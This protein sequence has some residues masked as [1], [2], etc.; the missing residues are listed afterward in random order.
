MAG[1]L[2]SVDEVLRLSRIASL[3]AEPGGKLAFT[4]SR[5]DPESNKDVAELV[6]LGQAGVEASY[7]EAGSPAWGPEG[8]LAFSSRRGAGEKEKGSG[9]YTLPPGLRGEPRRVAW[10]RHGVWGL[11]WLDDE[12][13]VA[14]SSVPE[15]WMYDD[16]GDYVA[17]RRLPLWFDGQ[18]LVAGR[19]RQL[20]L[21]EEWSGRTVK[22]TS[23]PYGVSSYAACDGNI[24]Y[25]TPMDWR[26]PT[27]HR[28]KLITRGG[29][30][31]T[32]AE[33]LHVSSIACHARGT[34]IALAHKGE[35]GI[36]SHNRLYLLTPDGHECLSCGSLDRNI[37][38]ASSDGD[39]I[40]MIVASGGR[41]PVYAFEPDR[42]GL[43]K[44]YEDDIVARA[45]AAYR[46]GVALIA[47]SPTV[48]PEVYRLEGGALHKATSYNSWISEYSLSKPRKITIESMGDTVEGWSSCLPRERRGGRGCL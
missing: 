1:K 3:R 31:R 42:S 27:A 10:L 14:G 19:T 46:G 48:P 11:E 24:Y 39:T 26:N 9:V 35:I 44:E 15:G 32:V 21:L 33:D 16:D 2:L 28:V 23:E 40:Y 17:T 38:G 18:G 7:A 5:P 22:L 6:V 29:E 12:R 36:A 4:V 37:W 13:L 41:T 20:F 47:S 43:R 34:A 30:E 8:R 25:A 45:I